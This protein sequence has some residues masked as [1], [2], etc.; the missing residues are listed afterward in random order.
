MFQGCEALSAPIFRESEPRMMIRQLALQLRFA[1]PIFFCLVLSTISLTQG[2]DYP[3]TRKD[4][5]VDDYHGTKVAD[6][7]RWLE[8][9]NSKE[10]AAWVAAENKVTFDYLEAIPQRP[11]LLDRLK[12]LWNYERFSVP[13][14]EGG[15]YFF[16][17]NPGLL[18]QARL[19]VA[20]TL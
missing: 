15:R 19:M 12:S 18:N 4:N 17:Q 14:K 6:P 1:L 10:T 9:D 11:K 3:Q 16:T 13:Q 8:D 2:L 20:D 5:Q 7:Y